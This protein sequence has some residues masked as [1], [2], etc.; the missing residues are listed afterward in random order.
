[1]NIAVSPR[2]SFSI[3]VCRLFLFVRFSENK[4]CLSVYFLLEMLRLRYL[5]GISFYTAILNQRVGQELEKDAHI[6]KVPL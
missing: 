4:N 3:A 2:L 1:M 6:F 5:S